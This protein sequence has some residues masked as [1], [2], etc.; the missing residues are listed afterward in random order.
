MSVTYRPHNRRRANRHGFRA[1]MKTRWGRKMLARRRRAGRWK[2]TVSDEPTLR[3]N[4]RAG[5]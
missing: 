2:L 5:H 4:R 1:K 3:R